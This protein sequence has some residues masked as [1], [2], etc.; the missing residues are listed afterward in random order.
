MFWMFNQNPLA[1][2]LV[3][4][5]AILSSCTVVNKYSPFQSDAMKLLFKKNLEIKVNGK[6]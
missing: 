4:Q 5:P 6:K 3:I 1:K 2:I